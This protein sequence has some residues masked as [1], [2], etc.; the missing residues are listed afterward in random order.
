MRAALHTAGVLVGVDSALP[1]VDRLLAEC[2]G[3]ELSRVGTGADRAYDELHIQVETSA[4]PFDTSGLTP[5]TR[6]AWGG[7]AGVVIHDVCTSGFDLRLSVSDGRATAAY[8]WRPPATSHLAAWMLRSRF[9]LLV[10]SVLLHYPAMWWA[11]TRGAVPLHAPAC[12]TGGAVALLAGPPGVG[13]TTLL[14][15][16]LANGARAISD[17]LSVTD[18]RECWGVVEPVRV[19]GGDGRRMPHGRREVALK[20]RVSSLVPDLVVVVRRGDGRAAELRGCDASI[21]TSALVASTYMAGELRRYWAF[22][23]TLSIGT[24]FGDVHPPIT[25]VASSLTHRLPCVELTLPSV[26]GTR[27]AE[28]VAPV[29]TTTCA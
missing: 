5:L 25:S 10:R 26:R 7:D 28:L 17:N 21:A 2:C 12:T 23:A 6:G 4:E 18:G 11:S 3:N 29:E 22:A 15:T 19:E 14:L 24:G 8:R 27:L 1:W 13:K 16:E 9:H 20:H